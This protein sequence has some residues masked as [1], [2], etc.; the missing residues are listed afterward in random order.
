MFGVQT[1]L[2]SG[3]LAR[4]AQSFDCGGALRAASSA[5][6]AGIAMAIAANARRGPWRRDIDIALRCLG[7]DWSPLAH[8]V[9]GLTNQFGSDAVPEAMVWVGYSFGER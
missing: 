3:S 7:R 9:P 4:F 6:S 5:H 2:Q 1:P 8:Y